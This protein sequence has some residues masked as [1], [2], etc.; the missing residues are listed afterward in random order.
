MHSLSCG[1]CTELW[2]LA[3]AIEPELNQNPLLTR[4]MTEDMRDNSEPL[5]LDG[6]TFRPSLDLPQAPA[7]NQAWMFW[8]VAVGTLIL[9][10]LLV[11]AYMVS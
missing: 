6:P 1:K 8:V 10:A 5:T 2:L 7:E 11:L 9:G 3:W 4:S